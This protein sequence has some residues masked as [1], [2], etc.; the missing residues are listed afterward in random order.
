[1]MPGVKTFSILHVWNWNVWMFNLK[2]LNNKLFVDILGLTIVNLKAS[3]N[4]LKT[5][6]SIS[7]HAPC[8]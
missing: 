6:P 8:K 1:M 3:K 7:G 4:D 2:T 5:V